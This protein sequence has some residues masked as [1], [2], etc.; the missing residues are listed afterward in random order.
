MRPE[1]VICGKPKP[2]SKSHLLYC[3]KPNCAHE[4]KSWRQKNWD[5][6][7]DGNWR[8]KLESEFWEVTDVQRQQ[9][10][11][12][13]ELMRP[14]KSHEK[15]RKCLKCGDLVA[16]KN[17]TTRNDFRLCGVCRANNVYYGALA[18]AQ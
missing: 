1:C 5:Q 10:P 4:Y 11:R 17:N 12:F 15:E 3:G 8:T 18:E 2:S 9:F 13:F 16:N 7:P 6:L 14:I